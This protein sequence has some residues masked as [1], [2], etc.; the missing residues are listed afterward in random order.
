MSL[1]LLTISFSSLAL[2]RVIQP[3]KMKKS[4]ARVVGLDVHPDSFAG[5][6]L[7]GR[8]AGSAKVLSFDAGGVAGIGEVGRAAHHRAR[9]PGP[10][11]R[12]GTGEARWKTSA[13]RRVTRYF[14]AWRRK[15]N[16][17]QTGPNTNQTMT[18]PNAMRNQ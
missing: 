13:R 10:C 14:G 6:I 7:E 3:K 12:A 8:E 5:A 16:K 18:E 9:S 4:N 1:Y 15:N 11:K 2:G 17:L